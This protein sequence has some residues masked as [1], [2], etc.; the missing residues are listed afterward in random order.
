MNRISFIKKIIRYVLLGIL[1]GIAILTGTKAAIF[2]DCDSCPGK[3]ICTG[4][5]DC[6]TF[7]NE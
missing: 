5:T 4:D 2:Y 3:G 6:S 7:L 1:G